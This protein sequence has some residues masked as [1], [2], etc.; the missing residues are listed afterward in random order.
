MRLRFILPELEA[1]TR[2]NPARGSADIDND[3]LNIP[4]AEQAADVIF[5]ERSDPCRGLESIMSP[6]FAER[7]VR[8]DLE[9]GVHVAATDL[10]V[11]QELNGS[12]VPAVGVTV[13]RVKALDFGG[14]NSRPETGSLHPSIMQRLGGLANRLRCTSTLPVQITRRGFE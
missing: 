2:L 12:A 13:R 14:C 8:H 10:I 6:Q 7:Q 9:R 4:R 1:F 3:E 5:G 11:V